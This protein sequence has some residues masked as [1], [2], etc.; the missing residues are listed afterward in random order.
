MHNISFGWLMGKTSE[1]QESCAQYLF[2]LANG[3]DIRRSR[4]MCAQYLLCWLMGK[5]SE[6]QE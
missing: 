6:D 5:I 1:D 4:V 3:E 2:W